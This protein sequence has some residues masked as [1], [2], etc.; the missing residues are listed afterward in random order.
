MMAL[1]A[2]VLGA[3][4]TVACSAF[5]SVALAAGACRVTLHAFRQPLQ[6]QRPKPETFSFILP[7]SGSFI[8][9]LVPHG[10]FVAGA[11]QHTLV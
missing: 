3:A 2:S 5:V 4:A 9:V 6:R 10:G 1:R 11:E 8:G 7:D